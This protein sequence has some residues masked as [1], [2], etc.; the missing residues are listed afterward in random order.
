MKWFTYVTDNWGKS[1]PWDY[2]VTVFETEMYPSLFILVRYL[3][4]L[5]DILIFKLN[6]RLSNLL[7][8]F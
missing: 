4:G 7:N 1:G 5:G 6:C 2:I 8:G 3:Y